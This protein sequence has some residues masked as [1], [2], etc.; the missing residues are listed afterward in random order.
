[1]FP[2]KY[3]RRLRT[4]VK[5]KKKKIKLVGLLFVIV[6][7]LVYHSSMREETVLEVRDD[8]ADAFTEDGDT[9]IAHWVERHISNGTCFLE[10]SCEESICCLERPYKD[11]PKELSCPWNRD[12]ILNNQRNNG[13]YDEYGITVALMYYAQPSILLQQLDKFMTYPGHLRRYLTLLIVDD[14]SPPGLRAQDIVQSRHKKS[15]R[16]RIA[17]VLKDVPWNTPQARNLAFYCTDTFRVLMIDSDLLVPDQTFTSLLKLPTERNNRAEA[18]RL[19][20]KLEKGVTRFHPS[21]VFMNVHGFWQAGGSDEDFS[22]NYGSE[23]TFFWHNFDKSGGAKVLEHE[24]FLEQNWARSDCESPRLSAET[25]EACRLQQKRSFSKNV[26]AN[27]MKS[28]KKMD[29]HCWSNSFLRVPWK[30]LE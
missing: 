27:S 19:N 2:S 8:L 5:N 11:A 13:D 16:I 1:M 26:T 9:T 24:I 29:T 15:F 17:V 22:G 30:L 23:D 20:R 25:Q 21:A 18:H 14:G 7:V 28:H 3:R 4:P 10:H 12:L 6:W